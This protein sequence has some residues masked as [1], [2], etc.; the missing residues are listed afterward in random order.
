M[1]TLPVIGANKGSGLNNMNMPYQS[2][3][4]NVSEYW[5]NH[6]LMLYP[7]S[8]IALKY[9]MIPAT[10]VPSETIFS[11]AGQFMSARRN[12]LLPDNL[13]TLVFLNKNM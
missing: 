12:R 1:D 2:L 3:N 10:S 11:K 4:C 8:E 13:D 9:I 7:L 6:K 5:S